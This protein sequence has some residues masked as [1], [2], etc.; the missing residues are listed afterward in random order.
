MDDDVERRRKKTETSIETN[1]DGA[2][3]S[4]SLTEMKIPGLH[5][6]LGRFETSPGTGHVEVQNDPVRRGSPLRAPS[7]LCGSRHES[8][9][10]SPRK[11]RSPTRIAL[12]ICL[13]SST[14]SLLPPNPLPVEDLP[15]KPP[16]SSTPLAPCFPGHASIARRG[17]LSTTLRSSAASLPFPGFGTSI[18]AFVLSFWRA[19]AS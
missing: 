15:S 13:A 2:S 5:Q 6:A 18:H 8:V 12:Q 10:R 16:R 4:R 9:P 17:L 19:I 1:G 3:F 14:A 11:E 7:I